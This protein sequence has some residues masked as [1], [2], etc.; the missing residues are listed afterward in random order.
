M[1]LEIEVPLPPAALSPNHSVGSL[2]ARLSKANR[3]ENYKEMVRLVALE[4]ARAIG[5]VPPE[6]ARISLVYG[7]KATKG[8]RAG[9]KLDRP[10]RP[11]DW[12]NAVSAFKAGQDGLVTK[13]ERVDKNGVRYAA[14]PGVLRG[15]DRQCLEGGSVTFEPSEGPWVRVTIEA[16]SVAGAVPM[17]DTN[18]EGDG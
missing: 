5:W 4:A 7:V 9:H 2:G 8:E 14:V 18:D 15:D 3:Y 10:Y 17:L 11:H 1:K 16:I 13:P 6:R 12:D